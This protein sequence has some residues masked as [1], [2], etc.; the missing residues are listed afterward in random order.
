MEH[1]LL[2]TNILIAV[3]NG[4]ISPD[5]FEKGGWRISISAVTVM[6]L[7]ALAGTGEGE[8]ER[9]ERAVD[10]FEVVPL[11][12]AIAKCAGMLARTRKT[13]KPDLLIAATALALEAALLT[14]NERDFKNIPG[15]R[16]LGWEDLY[17]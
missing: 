2:D 1:L 17:Q 11:G 6:E 12:R 13:G 16:V 7:Y 5:R 4:A 8:Q 3:L 14:E 15:L 10:M 9:I